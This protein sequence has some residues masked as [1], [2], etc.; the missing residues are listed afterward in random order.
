MSRKYWAY[1]FQWVL[2]TGG[3]CSRINW[4]EKDFIRNNKAFECMI[5]HESPHLAVSLSHLDTSPRPASSCRSSHNTF[6]CQWN[7][8]KPDRE[9]VLLNYVKYQK[10]CL[11]RNVHWQLSLRAGSIKFKIIFKFHAYLKPPAVACFHDKRSSTV[12]LK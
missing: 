12:S 11:A 9:K 1:K 6:W 3:T 10:W 2:Q 4:C 5:T 8:L 7:Q